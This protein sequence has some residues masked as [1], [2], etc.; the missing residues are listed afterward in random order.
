MTGEEAEPLKE[1]TSEGS[2]TEP[3]VSNSDPMDAQA[4]ADRVRDRA[5]DLFT[6]LEPVGDH[7]VRAEGM[8]DLLG[9]ALTVLRDKLGMD[10]L[11]AVTVVDRTD[12]VEGL[13]LVHHM[14]PQTGGAG[15]GAID[16]LSSGRRGWYV[17]RTRGAVIHVPLAGR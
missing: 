6:S 7:L 8:P 15:P 16:T 9:D 14:G 2:L 12:L 4:L 17:H 5:A 3:P 10:E 13:S 1:P 11:L